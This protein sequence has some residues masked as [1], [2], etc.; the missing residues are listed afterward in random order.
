MS[1]FTWFIVATYNGLGSSFSCPWHH[2][3]GLQ[4]PCPPASH[5]LP[6]VFEPTL[7]PR[8]HGMSPSPGPGR[9]EFSLN[10][11][12]FVLWR[13]PRS[14]VLIINYATSLLFLFILEITNDEI[15]FGHRK[16]YFCTSTRACQEK[17][18]SKLS[19]VF[20]AHKLFLRYD[21]AIDGSFLCAHMTFYCHFWQNGVLCV[22]RHFPWI[23]WISFVFYDW[24]SL[25]F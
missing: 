3:I 18:Q 23:L 11:E 14:C 21:H 8:H 9:M 16:Q 15:T 1:L 13:F 6:K 20:A 22:K 7:F 25:Y 10:W 5:P 24:L 19:W 12:A 2:G 17:L 4:H